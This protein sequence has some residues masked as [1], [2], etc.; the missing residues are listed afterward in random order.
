MLLVPLK[1]KA[2]SGFTFKGKI[3]IPLKDK[4]KLLVTFEVPV[5]L[6]VEKLILL[7]YWKKDRILYVPLVEENIYP[8]C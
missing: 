8:G 6:E 4:K 7:L 5:P 1:K 3:M 2:T